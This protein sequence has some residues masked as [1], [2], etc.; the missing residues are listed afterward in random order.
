M[1]DYDE[2]VTTD[3]RDPVVAGQDCPRC[4]Q[5]HWGE[6]AWCDQCRAE[7]AAGK[8]AFREARNHRRKVRR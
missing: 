6:G 2:W 8:R 3:P 1:I 7:H 4:G 5:E